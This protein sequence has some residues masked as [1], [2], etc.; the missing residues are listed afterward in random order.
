MN[1][2]V[3][4]LHKFNPREEALDILVTVIQ[5]F[6]D[7]PDLVRKYADLNDSHQVNQVVDALKRVT[8]TG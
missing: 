2:E 5:E 6:V 3:V 4:M 7:S 8:L 1:T